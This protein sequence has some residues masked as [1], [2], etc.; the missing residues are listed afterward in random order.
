MV[1]IAHQTR[2]ATTADFA[3][4]RAISGATWRVTMKKFA[5]SR[6]PSLDAFGRLRNNTMSSTKPEIHNKLHC[7]QRRTELQP[8]VTCTDNSV[9]FRRAVFEI[10]ERTERP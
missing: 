8:Q 9:M 6:T 1:H 5:T 4:G 3:T 2:E 7:R 10:N